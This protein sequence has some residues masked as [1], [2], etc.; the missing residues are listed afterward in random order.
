MIT[1]FNLLD[2]TEGL[3]FIL[4]KNPPPG[5]INAVSVPLS[6]DG[7]TSGQ[8]YIYRSGGQKEKPI[9]PF[10]RVANGIKKYPF[11]T[12]TFNPAFFLLENG[13]NAK[14]KLGS[15]LSMDNH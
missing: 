4:V 15:V 14:I 12:D 7:R 11:S 9:L 5:K 1:F 3:K 13:N 6:P 8:S 10:P 2:Y